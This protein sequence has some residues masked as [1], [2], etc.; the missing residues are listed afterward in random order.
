MED[1]VKQSI[2]NIQNALNIV[3][4]FALADAL[5]HIIPFADREDEHV[6]LGYRQ[7]QRVPSGLAF[8][9]LF[10]PIFHGISMYFV[11]TY[12]GNLA[13]FN[14]HGLHLLLDFS[15]IVLIAGLFV[16]LARLLAAKHTFLFYCTVCAVLV[17]DTLWIGSTFA[18]RIPVDQ[19][20]KDLSSYDPI[21]WLLINIIYLICLIV[22]LII[23]RKKLRDDHGVSEIMTWEVEEAYKITKE[24]ERLKTNTENSTGNN[25]QEKEKKRDARLLFINQFSYILALTMLLRTV[26]DYWLTWGYYFPK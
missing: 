11:R 25:I 3:F 21:W 23:F 17:V 2:E 14:N 15:L 22:L 13:N 8:F 24:D 6:T 9:F 4:A 1:V 7:A 10:T 16:V 20:K 19:L 18:R 12:Q 26:L 5:R